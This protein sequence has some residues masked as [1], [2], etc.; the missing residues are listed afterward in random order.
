MIVRI[1]PVDIAAAEAASGWPD[2]ARTIAWPSGTRAFEMAIRA[3]DDAPEP[4]TDAFRQQQFRQMLPQVAIALAPDAHEPMLRLAG[5]VTDLNLLPAWR[6]L[7][8]GSLQNRFSFSASR[9][10]ADSADPGEPI[11][12]SLCLAPGWPTLSIVCGDEHIGLEHA[13]R[14][15]LFVAPPEQIA[16]LLAAGGSEDG[17]PELLLAECS[18]IVMPSRQLRSLH[19]FTRLPETAAV[20]QKIMRQLIAVA[21]GSTI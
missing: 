12:A 19:L 13:V 2:A 5:P 8:S 6:H 17:I 1:D 3:G 21:S 16:P 4:M 9:R 20:R 11:V 7:L 10:P 18:V 15:E 14:T